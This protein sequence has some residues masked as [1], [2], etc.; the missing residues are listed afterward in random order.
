MDGLIFVGFAT[1]MI[2]LSYQLGKSMIDFEN[3]LKE[4]TE[5]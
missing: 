3:S 1:I 2:M 4:L 5:I